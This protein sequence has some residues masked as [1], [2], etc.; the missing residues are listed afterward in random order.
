MDLASDTLRPGFADPVHDAQRA[1]RAALHAL[2][3]P[4]T[5]VPVDV[6]PSLPPGLGIAAGSALLALLD[7]DTRLWIAPSPSREAIATYLRFHTGCTLAADPAQ[8]DFALVTDPAQLPDLE[9]FDAGRDEHPER[10]ATV[11][12]EVAALDGRGWRLRGPGIETESVMAAAIAAPFVAQWQAQRR[13]F[14][15]GVDVLL[16]S[17]ATLAGLPRTCH[18]T[19]S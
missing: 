8:C 3:R 11:M 15:R 2:S 19:E 1:F 17:G 5:Q 12:V 14:P 13:R 16:A 9:R 18:L 7:A 10:S 4:G 6:T